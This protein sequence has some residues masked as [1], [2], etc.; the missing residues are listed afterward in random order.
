MTHDV[1][2]LTGAYAVDALTDTERRSF[3]RHLGECDTCAVEVRGL[4]A[5]A[6]RLGSA[7]SLVPSQ[8]FR[9][10]VLTRAAAT[11]Q[12]PPRF[13]AESETTGGGLSRIGRRPLLAAAAALAVL[14]TGLG[15]VAVSLDQ[16]ADD[17]ERLVAVA[18]DPR[19]V[20]AS[21]AVLNGGTATAV[22][23]DGAAVFAAAG[24]PELRSD[25]DF[26]LWALS[27]EGAPASLGVVEPDASGSLR[28]L[29]TV[30]G[31]GERLALT[32]EPE[33]GSLEPTT[34]PVVVLEFAA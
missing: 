20:T 27:A 12:L 4:Q 26:Q 30:L 17:A 32:V 10:R 16:R 28:Q 21:D 13:G 14:A 24:L 11:R 22:R 7:E 5:A 18:L 2:T 3:E 19:G 9:D 8:Q 31:E 1:H 29:V 25:Q 33:G 23:A 34:E 15:A 6:A